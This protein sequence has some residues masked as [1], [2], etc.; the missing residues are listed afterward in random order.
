QTSLRIVSLF[1]PAVPELLGT[2]ETPSVPDDISVS[3]DGR[4]YLAM[5]VAGLG[6]ADV[7]SVGSPTLG[8]PVSTLFTAAVSVGE[9]GGQAVLASVERV[10]AGEGVVR[11]YTL[12]DPDRP[13]LEGEDDLRTN[14]IEF[15]PVPFDLEW[16]DDRVII[17]AGYG[18]LQFADLDDLAAPDVRVR[19]P[20][21]RAYVASAAG[22]VATNGNEFLVAD[23]FSGTHRGE[24]LQR[25]LTGRLPAAGVALD[26]EVDPA[27]GA[28]YVADGSFGVAVLQ[29]AAGAVGETLQLVGRAHTEDWNYTTALSQSATHVYAAD[30]FGG[31]WTV[32][33]ATLQPVHNALRDST[34]REVAV[35]EDG[36][37][38]LASREACATAGPSGDDCRVYVLSLADPSAPT[39]VSTITPPEGASDLAGTGPVAW[40]GDF[41]DSRLR[42]Y[43]LTDPAAPEASGDVPLMGAGFRFARDGDRLYALGSRLVANILDVSTPEAP[44]VLGDAQSVTRSEGL[45][46]R[47]G[48]LVLAGFGATSYD[49]RDPAST[50]ETAF[51]DAFG[52]VQSGAAFVSEGLAVVGVGHAGVSLVSVPVPVAAEGPTPLARVRVEAA[53]NPTRGALSL[54]IATPEA[55]EVAVFDA[56]GRRVRVLARGLRGDATLAWD[57]RSEAGTPLAPGVYVV[58]VRTASGA[59]ATTRVTVV[60]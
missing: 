44:V 48:V 34:I 57:G 32:D 1:D 19:R 30:G 42:I 59:E 33:K 5:N 31:I 12:V 16:D 37:L 13:A 28:I 15:G 6:V 60:R 7:T 53:P 45:A 40:I 29:R 10:A 24:L 52:D 54:R 51:S 58:R 20:T 22:R 47:G 2:L 9:V 3:E 18:G 8:T 55:A 26:V 49:V 39:L 50:F 46:V 36:G 35:T 25:A 14:T 38:L 41:S 27:S 43:D 23:L 17:G 11:A 56:L 4:A 21:N